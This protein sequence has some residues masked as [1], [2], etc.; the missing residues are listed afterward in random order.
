MG[1]HVQ[2]F[3]WAGTVSYSLVQKVILFVLKWQCFVIQF[4]KKIVADTPLLRYYSNIHAELI[5][6]L[7]IPISS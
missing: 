7:I 5:Y 6:V 1:H 4:L 2:A 3:V